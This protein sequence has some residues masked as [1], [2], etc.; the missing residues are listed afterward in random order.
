MRPICQVGWMGMWMGGWCHV[1]CWVDR[2]LGRY[3][4]AA[5]LPSWVDG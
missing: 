3:V 4:A 1:G 2:W 5:K